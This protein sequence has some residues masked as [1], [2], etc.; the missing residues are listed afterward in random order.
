MQ[1]LH[2]VTF[3][4]LFVLDI[5]QTLHLEI[6]LKVLEIH[7]FYSNEGKYLEKF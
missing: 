7:F 6:F 1:D 3:L 2:G 4:L 5:G